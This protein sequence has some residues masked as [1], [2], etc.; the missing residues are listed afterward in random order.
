MSRPSHKLSL[1][2]KS[3]PPLSF[4]LLTSLP[5]PLP[6][7]TCYLLPSILGVS[8]FPL[9]FSLFSGSF[10]EDFE[11][12]CSSLQCFLWCLFMYFIVNGFDWS[13]MDSVLIFFWTGFFWEKDC[14]FVCV[15]VFSFVSF[16]LFSFYGI[17]GFLN[18]YDGIWLVNHIVFDFGQ[19]LTKPEIPEM[20]GRKIEKRYREYFQREK[21][22]KISGEFQIPF[23]Y[24]TKTRRLAL[25]KHSPK[26]YCRLN[27]TKSL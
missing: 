9:S 10:I 6:L 22:E 17:F 11:F 13:F 3:L 25:H 19:W 2:H 20:I 4:S 15:C 27:S 18:D 21:R 23:G 16:I 12:W 14:E 8:H 24:S 7:A 1:S 26:L 5:L